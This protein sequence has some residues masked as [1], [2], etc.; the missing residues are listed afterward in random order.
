MMCWEVNK[1][2]HKRK[3]VCGSCGAHSFRPG[4]FLLSISLASAPFPIPA[5]SADLFRDSE[6]CLYSLFHLFPGASP[7]G[8]R[9]VSNSTTPR[10]CCLPLPASLPIP[11]SVF[12]DKLNIGHECSEPLPPHPPRP[13]PPQISHPLPALYFT[14]GGRRTPPQLATEAG[15][16]GAAW[17]FRLGWWGGRAAGG[18]LPS[19]VM[20]M[21]CCVEEEEGEEEACLPSLAWALGR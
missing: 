2:K 16:V 11:T 10:V 18:G 3:V 14:A 6:S 4:W 1:R 9:M 12:E 20:M 17:K 5:C 15:G 21:E 13:P 7:V 19:L 8:T